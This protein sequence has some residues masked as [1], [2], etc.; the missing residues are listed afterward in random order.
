MRL[1]EFNG[2]RIGPREEKPVTMGARFSPMIVS[3]AKL[4]EPKECYG[5]AM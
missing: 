1:K 2:E 4:N 5:E 3:P